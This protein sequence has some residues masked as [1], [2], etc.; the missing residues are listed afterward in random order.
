MYNHGMS[1]MSSI[2]NKEYNIKRWEII[3]TI[4]QHLKDNK[5]DVWAKEQVELLLS[6][7]NI[8]RGGAYGNWN[9]MDWGRL[10]MDLESEQKKE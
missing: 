1:N 5:D 10:Y 9:L 7:H 6:L 8:T 3:Q 2:P 4:K